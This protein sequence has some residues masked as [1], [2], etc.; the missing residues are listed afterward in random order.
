[1]GE[2]SVTTEKR[3]CA[4]CGVAFQPRSNRQRFC[5][6]CGPRGRATCAHCGKEF[7]PKGNTRGI[8]CSLACWGASVSSPERQRRPCPVCGTIF[9]PKLARQKTCSRECG[10]ALQRRPLLTCPVCGKEYDSRHRSRTC[11]YECAGKI[12]QLPRNHCER[13][14]KPIETRYRL[15]RFC[16]QECRA[17]P[18]G[19]TLTT[20][21]GYVRVK[22][23]KEYPGADK[24]GYVMEHRYVMEQKLDRPLEPHE[25]VHHRNGDRSDNREENLE[26]RVGRHG[27]GADAP[28]CPTCT[29]FEH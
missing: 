26:L 7:R 3:D 13:C 23:G 16:S 6:D 8:Y 18:L 24:R 4:T 29:C 20:A 21:Q 17:L 9:K 19:T 1:M 27:R 5:S 14:G 25:T 11:S 22:V 12:R 15:Q 10:A 28:H 2:A